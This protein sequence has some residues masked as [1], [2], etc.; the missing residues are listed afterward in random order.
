MDLF[1]ILKAKKGIP[2]SDS[3]I[4]NL[5]QSYNS[6]PV[7]TEYSGIVPFIINSAD[8]NIIKWKLFG[9]G[10]IQN[11]TPFFDNPSAIKGLGNLQ[12]NNEYSTGITTNNTI[13][14]ELHHSYP[15]FDG[16]TI[17][18][19]ESSAIEHRVWAKKV[20]EIIA[21]T[22]YNNHMLGTC[23]FSSSDILPSTI[24]ADKTKAKCDKAVVGSASKID[25]FYINTTNIAFVGTA[26]DTLETLKARYDGAVVY[27]IAKEPFEQQLQISNMHIYKGY[28]EI[29]TNTEIKPEKMNITYLK[30]G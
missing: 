27:Y 8:K 7:Q 23:K 21:V 20:I 18:Y 19:H 16:D 22:P 3:L 4:Y 28:N 13:F 25:S 1:K 14:A 17:E 10:P 6:E 9:S 11:D 15:Y 30:R 29:N 5:F 26:D 2:V 24:N 12:T